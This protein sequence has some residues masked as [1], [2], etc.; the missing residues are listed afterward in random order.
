MKAKYVFESIDDLLKAKTEEEILN[1]LEQEHSIKDEEVATKHLHAAIYTDNVP[2]AKFALGKGGKPLRAASTG[3]LWVAFNHNGKNAQ[4]IL[5][6]MLKTLIKELNNDIDFQYDVIKK[7]VYM[8]FI[9]VLQWLFDNIELY[10]KALDGAYF[11][12]PNSN[13]K[14]SKE[15]QEM[16]RLKI[17]EIKEA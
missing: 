12:A 8:G 15:A 7:T 10:A 2:Y 13:F 11:D 9:N 6:L 16:L 14:N 17:K 3:N 5:L 4:E 1:V